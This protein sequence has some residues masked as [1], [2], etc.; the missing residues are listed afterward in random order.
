MKIYCI[1]MLTI[2]SNWTLQ[3]QDLIEKVPVFEGAC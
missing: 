3:S 2:L 1:I